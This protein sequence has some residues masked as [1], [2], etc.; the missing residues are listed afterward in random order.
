M[1][2]IISSLL[3][4]L[5]HNS[6]SA[7][8][9]LIKK[10][11]IFLAFYLSIL[12]RY[13][14]LREFLTLKKKNY[15]NLVQ[16]VKLIKKNEESVKL[17]K[18]KRNINLTN[19]R[20][21]FL[22]PKKYNFKNSWV[23]TAKNLKANVY[24]IPTDEVSYTTLKS[25]S[26]NNFEIE[27]VKN[28]K[29]YRPDLI[30][31]DVNYMGN[32]NTINIKLIKKIKNMTR[33][34]IKI[35]GWIG[36]IYSMS[37]LDIVKYWI[38]CLDLVIYSEPNANKILPIKSIKKLKYIN[39]C[40][41]EKIFF[42]EKKNNLCFFSGSGNT[43][44]YPYLIK[45]LKNSY[46]KKGYKIFFQ[47]SYKTLS[48]SLDKY[49]E[50]IRKSKSVVNLSSRNVPYLRVLAGR[51]MEAIASKT[52]LIEEKNESISKLFKPYR[53]FIPFDSLHELS[54]AIKF[55][56]HHPKLVNK[57]CDNAYNQYFNKYN[58]KYFWARVY[59][60]LK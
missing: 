3:T 19:K 27:L 24:F 47:N 32:N 38:R 1:K 15:N 20:I 14:F 21:F 56:K 23:E 46:K 34:N 10:N 13:I 2:N 4:K 18:K 60:Y 57:I 53:D 41:N 8:F 51:A 12:L 17:I 28:I 26:I 59:S 44:R 16:L 50:T 31:M 52:L 30:F 55:V 6:E 42:P 36:D 22:G 45:L 40:V 25:G 29:L 5:K 11:F 43:S 48:L 37:S 35:V 54:I 39:F 9:F 7:V 49:S 33:R 58:S